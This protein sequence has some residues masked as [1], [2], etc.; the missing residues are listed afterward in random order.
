[1]AENKKGIVI[2][3][4]ILAVIIV[5]SVAGTVYFLSEN[6]KNTVEIICDGVVV[7]RINLPTEQNRTI[8][9]ERG[10]S[11][12]TIE[13]KDG[14]IFVSEADCPDQICVKTGKLKGD[15]PIVCLPNRLVIRCVDSGEV[16]AVA[17]QAA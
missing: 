13:I 8:H 9:I 14:E 6:K 3:Y 5:L 4:V 11:Y 2:L 1:M 17:G 10:G 16:D 12:N 15:M 7:E